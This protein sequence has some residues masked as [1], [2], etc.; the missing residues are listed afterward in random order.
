[1]VTLDLSLNDL[2]VLP[3]DLL[4]SLKSL[5]RLNLRNNTLSSLPSL[6]TELLHLDVSYNE[7]VV[8]WSPESIEI[9]SVVGNL[10]TCSSDSGKC[11]YLGCAPA[12]FAGNSDRSWRLE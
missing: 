12:S 4:G 6:P 2:V 9:S 11:F 7:M 5:E 3:T 1:V 10:E 8:T